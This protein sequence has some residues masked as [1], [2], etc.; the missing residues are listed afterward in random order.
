MGICPQFDICWPDLDIEDHLYFYA[1][2]KG[3]NKEKEKTLVD[4]LINEVGLS[5]AARSKK[6]SQRTEW[7]Y[8]E[9]ACRLQWP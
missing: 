5:E 6:K 7:W 4:K 3:I 9:G 1:R 8:A 2:L